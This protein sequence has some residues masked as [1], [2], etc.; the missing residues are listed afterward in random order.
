M[1]SRREH[2]AQKLKKWDI[3]AE[4]IIRG[5]PQITTEEKK[6]SKVLHIHTHAHK[7]THTHHAHTP[8]TS[9][10]TLTPTHPHTS[11][12]THTHTHPHTPPPL[13]THRG[14]VEKECE[15]GMLLGPPLLLSDS[16]GFF[17]VTSCFS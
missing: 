2:K 3:R 1:L 10:S 17:R 7:L 15:G 4:R 16:K 9:T 13:H 8:C 6:E 14:G 11:I 5:I 12:H